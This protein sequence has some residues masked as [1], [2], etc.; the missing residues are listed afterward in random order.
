MSSKTKNRRRA[1]K[2][3]YEKAVKFL[4]AAE[5]LMKS[6]SPDFIGFAI[7]W[8]IRPIIADKMSR[9]ERYKTAVLLRVA[10]LSKVMAA[11]IESEA[12][13]GATSD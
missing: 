8:H 6:D 9:Q 5:R 4:L 1:V 12:G 3:R 10:A 13:N 2:R 7:R 11:K